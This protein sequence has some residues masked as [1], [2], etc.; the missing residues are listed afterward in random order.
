M[1]HEAC[2]QGEVM[3]VQSIPVLRFWLLPDNFVCA[4]TQGDLQQADTC[5]ETPGG[6][7]SQPPYLPGHY[8]QH[9]RSVAGYRFLSIATSILVD[10]CSVHQVSL[11]G[12][13]PGSKGR[14]RLCQVSRHNCMTQR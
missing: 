12:R 14:S 2:L 10:T 3:L 1:G 5:A 13:K 9:Y 6:S 4:A 8:P 7:P 11:Y